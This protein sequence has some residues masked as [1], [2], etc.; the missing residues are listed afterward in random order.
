MTPVLAFRDSQEGLLMVD[1]VYGGVP[2]EAVGI[3]VYGVPIVAVVGVG[4]LMDRGAGVD[5]LTVAR[6]ISPAGFEEESP[7]LR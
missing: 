1:H 5:E 3:K 6:K 2:P 4:A 7:V